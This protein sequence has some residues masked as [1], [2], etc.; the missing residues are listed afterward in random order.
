MT[1]INIA[2][3]GKTVE[4][5]NYRSAL[6]VVWISNAH[7]FQKTLLIGFIRFRLLFI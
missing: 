1:T 2:I 7:F 3:T 4:I 5:E 6:S